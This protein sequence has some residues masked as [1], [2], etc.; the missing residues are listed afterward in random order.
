M[1]DKYFSE[2]KLHSYSKTVTIGSLALL[3]TDSYSDQAVWDSIKGSEDILAACAI[4]TALIG[5]GNKILG[6]FKLDG[7]EMSVRDIYA[8]KGVNMNA[9][10]GSKLEPGD[11]TPRRLHRAF[12][13]VIRQF[14]EKTPSVSS[15]LWRKYSSRDEKFRTICYPGS[16]HLVSTKEEAEY[17]LE[18]YKR[19]DEKKGTNISE[20]IQRVL[21]A[22]S[23]P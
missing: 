18:T 3:S 13:L 1:S 10:L 9:N 21:E 20:R 16:E 7:Q 12:R 23:Y 2:A 6:S 19:L 11:M 14:L 17:L 5:S 4:Q 8:A 22:R 15:Y